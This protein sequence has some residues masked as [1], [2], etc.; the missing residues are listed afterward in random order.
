[1]RRRLLSRALHHPLTLTHAPVAFC[2]ALHLTLLGSLMRVHVLPFAF[3]LPSAKDLDLG[4]LERKLNSK[5]EAGLRS[6]VVVMQKE[7]MFRRG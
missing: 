6:L 1:M 4:E 3:R 7:A 2:L 5:T